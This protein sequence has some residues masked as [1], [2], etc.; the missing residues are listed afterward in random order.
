VAGIHF[1]L[2]APAGQ[3]Y[4]VFC[5]APSRLVRLY[6][7]T[8]EVT[9][10]KSWRE[11]AEKWCREHVRPEPA[12]SDV[13]QLSKPVVATATPDGHVRFHF[14]VPSSPYRRTKPRLTVW[15]YDP[16]ADRWQDRLLPPSFW[17]TSNPDLLYDVDSGAILREQSGKW[18]ATGRLPEDWP[19]AG[20]QN[21]PMA[22]TE[23]HLYIR[24]PLGLY[25]VAREDIQVEGR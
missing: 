18:V 6:G 11:H 2:G 13:A 14:W 16:G 19:T 23:R 10:I 8:G 20:T 5:D 1:R 3:S 4:Y 21:W 7:Q 9:E 12:E 25:R 17:P 22:A 24:A 15:R